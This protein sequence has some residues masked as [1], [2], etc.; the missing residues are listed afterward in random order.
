MLAHIKWIVIALVLFGCVALFIWGDK[1]P[2]GSIFAG[3]AAFIAA[4]KTKLFGNDKLAEKIS[5]IRNSHENKRKDWLM[6]KEKYEFQYDQMK[7]RIEKLSKRVEILNEQLEQTTSPENKAKRR[8]E[9]EILF[10]L[11][12]N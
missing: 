9:E 5:D 10:W 12:K 6:E 11:T 3:M 2:A 7:T 8:S 4:L 1:I